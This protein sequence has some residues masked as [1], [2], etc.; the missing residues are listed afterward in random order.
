MEAVS[1][2]A[3]MLLYVMSFLEAKD[4]CSISSTDHHHRD[5]SY[6]PIMWKE[7]SRTKKH[8]RATKG[9]HPRDW[10]IQMEARIE[11][12]ICFLEYSPNKTPSLKRSCKWDHVP[13]ERDVSLVQLE[14][15]I[16]AQAYVPPHRLHLWK[17]QGDGVRANMIPLEPIIDDKE[18]GIVALCN[19]GHNSELVCY[20]DRPMG[21]IGHGP[22][23][24]LEAIK[25]VYE[26]VTVGLPL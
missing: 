23:D 24:S 16:G 1:L 21:W 17:L 25:R 20:I 2:P 7:L 5:L 8:P 22:E 9:V 13:V 15:A 18:P 14:R 26:A 6:D 11:L 4:L 12:R 3:E 19:L 10:Y